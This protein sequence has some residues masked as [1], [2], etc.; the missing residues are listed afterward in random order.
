MLYSLPVR[1]GVARPA[2][3]PAGIVVARRLGA[4]T[5]I[6]RPSAADIINDPMKGP[7]RSQPTGMDITAAGDEV[8]VMTYGDVYRFPRM[9]DESWHDAMQRPPRVLRK[10]ASGQQTEALAYS[11]DASVLYYTSEDRRAPIYRYVRE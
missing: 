6:P 7:Y 5:S 10:P 3:G 2:R 8:A 4:V 1:P 9:S 11:T